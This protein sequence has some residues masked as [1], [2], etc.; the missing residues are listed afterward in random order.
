MVKPRPTYGISRIDQ[1]FKKNHGFYV[2][3][4][5]NGTL[6]QKFFPDKASGGKNKALA[7]ARAYRDSIVAS[8]P[9][10][11]QESVAK[12]RRKIKHSGITGVTHVIAK[13]PDGRK[14]YEYWQAAWDDPG[15]G[16]KTAKFSITRYGE[17]AAME[18]A[19]KARNGSAKV[20]KM[21]S[22]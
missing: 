19:V 12:K 9:L 15:E 18:M 7:L 13:S 1:D 11:K 21:A 17:K 20:R 16:R 14:T 8:L 3:I 2:R 10:A 5:H 22:R 6:H 4:T